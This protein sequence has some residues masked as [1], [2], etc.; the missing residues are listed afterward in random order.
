WYRKAAEQGHATAQYNLGL[1]YYLGQGVTKDLA[2]AVKWLRKSAEQGYKDAQKA[3][4][5]MGE[6]L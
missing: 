2:E 4:V 5:R 1:C 6:T 3:L